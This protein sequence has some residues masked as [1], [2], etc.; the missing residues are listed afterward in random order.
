MGKKENERS[1][2]DA[3][4]TPPEVFEPVLKAMGLERFDLDPCSHPNAIV[5]VK[6]R[7]LLPEYE[8]W[9]YMLSAADLGGLPGHPPPQERIY[10][11]GLTVDWTGQDVWKNPPYSQLQHAV[12]TRKHPRGKYPW[13]WKAANE[14]KRCAAFLPSRTASRWW[15]EGILQEP[16]ADIL[17]QLRGRVTHVGEQWGSPFHQ[18]VVGF[19]MFPYGPAADDV[20]SESERQVLEAWRVAFDHPRKAFVS[21]LREMRR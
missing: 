3:V 12:A 6:R 20:R 2:N 5:P 7:V 19:G 4:C 17:V 15:H 8:Q 13:L 18:V 16:R 10:G 11:D 1:T 21:S 9:E 14:A